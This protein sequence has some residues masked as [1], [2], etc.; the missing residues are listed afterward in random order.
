MASPYPPP[1]TVK[2]VQ[3]GSYFVGQY[4]QVLQQHPDLVHRFYADGSTI[5]R[6]D[7]HS[8]DSANTMLQIHALVMSLNFSA[9]EIKT[10]N[11]LESWNGGVLVMVSGSVKTKDFVNRRKFVQTFFL[12]PQEKGYFVLNDIFHF[13]DDGVVYQQNLAP[14]P[15]ENMYMQHPVAVSSDETFDAQLDSSHSP[16]EPPVS[17]YVLEEEAR[18]YVN[19]VR[20]DD[21]PVDKYSLPEQQEQQDFETEIVVDETPVVETPASFQSA[22]NVGQDFPT[23]APEEPMEEPQKKTYASILLV[24]KGL[25]SSSVVTQPPVNRSAPTTSDWNHMP[26]TS[27][28]QPESVS[29]AT[30]TGVEATEESFGVDEGQACDSTLKALPYNMTYSNYTPDMTG[31]LEGVDELTAGKH[32]TLICEPKSVYVRNLPSDVTAA[33]IEE[34]FKHFGRIKPDGVFVRNRKDVVG[35]CYAFV[36]FEDLLSVQNAIKAS[37]I[38]LAGRPVYIEERRPS[39]SIASRGG[40]IGSLNRIDATNKCLCGDCEV[41]NYKC[42]ITSMAKVA[43]AVF[44]LVPEEEGEVTKQMRQGGVLVAEVWEGEAIK[45]VVT[46][47]EQ[48]AM[49]SISVLSDRTKVIRE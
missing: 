40:S 23:A 16:P 22:V 39:T 18:E 27:A 26:T 4:Y 9:I 13:V 28:L 32:N 33:E 7:A 3:V 8:T 47:T 11:S 12:A 30:E 38:Q 41:I 46:T 15:S 48:E 5:I 36:E 42:A 44:V 31:A 19:S 2:A 6:I 37:P 24:S 45:M 29:Y 35:V 34:E 1:V 17:D 25:S 10:I 14:R 20:I 21:D 43:A 49:V